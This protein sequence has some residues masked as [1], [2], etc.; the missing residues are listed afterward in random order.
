METADYQL[1]RSQNDCGKKKQKIFQYT[2]PLL[3]T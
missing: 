3:G 2:F 1:E